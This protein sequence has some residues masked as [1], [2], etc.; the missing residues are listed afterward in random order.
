MTDGLRPM[1]TI[2]EFATSTLSR[3]CA[4]RQ[5][6]KRVLCH[7][8]IVLQRVAQRC[9]ACDSRML[10]DRLL[11]QEREIFGHLV[12]P[13]SI[14]KSRSGVNEGVRDHAELSSCFRHARLPSRLRNSITTASP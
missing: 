8:F 13:L 6:S 14:T 11:D 2:I 4:A 1:L 7:G 9:V 5:E 10:F 3:R 12:A